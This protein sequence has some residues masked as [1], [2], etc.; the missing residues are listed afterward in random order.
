MVA[1]ARFSVCHIIENSA[2]RM[3]HLTPVGGSTT[4]LH[5]F[6]GLENFRVLPQ[7]NTDSVSVMV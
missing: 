5:G 7:S 2:K 3:V 4:D 1:G 6:H